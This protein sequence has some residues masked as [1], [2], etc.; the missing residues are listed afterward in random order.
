MES[1][2]KLPKISKDSDEECSYEEQEFGYDGYDE[3]NY[4]RSRSTSLERSFSDFNKE[5]LDEQRKFGN[6]GAIKYN[7]SI[8]PQPL[9][10]MFNTKI[11]QA[12]QS[13]IMSYKDTMKLIDYIFVSNYW[14]KRKGNAILVDSKQILR[15]I[16]H[17]NNIN[18]TIL[19]SKT[20][21]SITNTTQYIN[22]I[23][24]IINDKYKIIN[25]ILLLG[26]GKI[27][28]CGGSLIQL[29]NNG[30]NNNDWDLFFHCETVNEGDRL[31]YDCLQLIENNHVSDPQTAPPNHCRTQRVHTVEYNKLY[32]KSLKIQFIKRIYKSK[33]QVLLGFDLAPSRIGYNPIDGLYATVC[34]GLSIAMK[35]FPLDTTQR[36]MSFGHRLYKYMNKG[37]SILYPGLP[38]KLSA[39]IPT[40]DGTLQCRNNKIQFYHKRG[41]ESDY[42]GNEGSHLNWFYILSERDHL[43]TF[44]G[45]MNEVTELNDDFVRKSIT[46]HELFQVNKDCIYSINIK[47]NKLFLGDK[48]KD[49]ID[50]YIINEDEQTACQIWKE[51]CKWY[52]EK[53]IK[54]AQSCRKN[55]W[56][57]EDPGSQSFG[58]FN[59]ILEHPKMWYG[60][61]YQSVEVGIKTPQ[62]RA[63]M[64]CFNYIQIEI[65]EK[66]INL[67]CNFW[68]EA[69][70]KIA[71]DYLYSLH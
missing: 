53:G 47:T 19:S 51:K 17:F 1:S 29:I 45:N 41:F 70:V 14:D 33:D 15:W 40:P 7:S 61:N 49:F 67:I 37:F 20:H 64:S 55:S 48:Y 54:I 66:I 35:C 65:P 52:V 50:A 16:N 60:N 6:T 68:L 8:I 23:S 30:D 21:H 18:F 58:K 44:E 28:L 31:L 63:F 2:F 3:T 34:G 13:K 71:R 36:S 9:N 32:Y 22:K 59:P 69:E 42:D 11:K 12:D 27:S 56:K 43:I 38:M 39:D 57:T 10:N 25:D 4:N 46:N 26:N 5:F 24:S 62:F